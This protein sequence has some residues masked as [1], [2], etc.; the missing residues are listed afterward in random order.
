MQCGQLL[1]KPDGDQ[2][3]RPSQSSVPPAPLSPFPAL[4]T[5]P[6]STPGLWPILRT[7]LKAGS[8]ASLR[9]PRLLGFLPS[10]YQSHGIATMP[11]PTE[12]IKPH[13]ACPTA[14]VAST[15]G[16]TLFQAF[17]LAWHTRKCLKEQMDD[18]RALVCWHL[19][20]CSLKGEKVSGLRAQ[21]L[22]GLGC[23]FQTCVTL[24]LPLV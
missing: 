6:L 13:I 12:A 10:W 20:V 3:R 9:A 22:E 11:F 1:S 24:G 2:C 7:Q 18:I 19:Q 14:R 23:I 21:A 8:W 5:R 4:S 15:Y 16:E 17:C